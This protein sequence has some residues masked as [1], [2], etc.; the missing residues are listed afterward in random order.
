[1]LMHCEDFA[2]LITC[3]DKNQYLIE[4]IDSMAKKEWE[5]QKE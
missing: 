1:M 3:F 5:I 4:L 2:V